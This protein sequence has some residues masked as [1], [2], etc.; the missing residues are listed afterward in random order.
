MET[1]ISNLISPTQTPSSPIVLLSSLN[2]IVNSKFNSNSLLNSTPSSLSVITNTQSVVSSSSSSLTIV[3][4]STAKSVLDYMLDQ[5]KD[6]KK[7]NSTTVV[8]IH[9]LSKLHYF[10]RINNS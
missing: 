5:A 1:N 10:S 9:R 7:N 6:N 4:Q 8:W 3:S 2:Q